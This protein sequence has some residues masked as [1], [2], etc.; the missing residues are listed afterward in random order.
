MFIVS[1]FNCDLE[2]QLSFL[3][4]EGKNNLGFCGRKYYFLM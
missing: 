3:V 2:S 4:E 1:Y